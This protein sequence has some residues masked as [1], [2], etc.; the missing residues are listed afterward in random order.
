MYKYMSEE[1]AVCPGAGRRALLSCSESSR[2]V[3]TYQP[4]IDYEE[5]LSGTDLKR[6]EEVFGEVLRREKPPGS[7]PQRLW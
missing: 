1:L 7:D 2:E 4:P 5:L 6:L 3:R